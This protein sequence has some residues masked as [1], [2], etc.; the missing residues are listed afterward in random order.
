M[1][2]F[3][4]VRIGRCT[5][6]GDGLRHIDL[7]RHVGYAG[8]HFTVGMVLGK[9]RQRISVLVE[10][11]PEDHQTSEHCQQ[12]ADRSFIFRICFYVQVDKKPITEYS[13]R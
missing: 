13:R 12:C 4:T 2:V 3:G 8:S 7:V 6:I 10:Y 1:E 9:H 11:G 5:S